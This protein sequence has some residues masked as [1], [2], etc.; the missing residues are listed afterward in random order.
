MKTLLSLLFITVL[1]FQQ[2]IWANSMLPVEVLGSEG[3]IEEVTFEWTRQAKAATLYL[4]ANNLKYSNKGSLRLND[5]GWLLFNNNNADCYQPD[6]GFG[7]IGG[8]YSTIRFTIPIDK[9]GRL[10]KGGNILQFRFDKSDEVS[11][12]YR[13][14]DINFLDENGTFLLGEDQ[15]ENDDPSMWEVPEI[16][17]V[18]EGKQLWYT[19]QL[20]QS[21]AGKR[22][23]ATCSDCHAQ[24][25][26]DLKYFNYSNKSIIKRAEFHGL[27]TMEGK[28]IAD[29]IR[30]LDTPAP[31]QARPWN[32]PYQPGPG[33]DDIPAIEWAAGA[34]LEWVLDR[35]EQMMP[36]LLPYGTSKEGIAKVFD[37]KATLNVREMPVAI[38]FPDWKQW[39]P[40]VHPK[41]LMTKKDWTASRMYTGYVKVR[42]LFET[43]GTAGLN[44]IDYGL[45]DAIM[46]LSNAGRMFLWEGFQ[47]GLHPWT[48]LESTG[49][50]KNTSNLLN[51]DYKLNIARWTSVK[52]WEIMQEFEVEGVTPKGAPVPEARQWP[53]R[54][55]TLFALAPHIVGDERFTSHFQ[56]QDPVVGYYE[57]TAWYQ[58]QLTLN[59]GMRDPREVEPVDWSYN[60]MHILRASRVTR[61]LEP[62]RYFQNIL[63]CYQQ[64]DNHH[65]V[66]RAGWT[67]REVSPWRNYSSSDGYDDDFVQ[68]DAYEPGLRAKLTGAMV[69]EFTRKANEFE[70]SDWPVCEDIRNRG[71][72]YWWCIEPKDYVPV[73]SYDAC[74]FMPREDRCGDSLDA[75]EADAINILLPKLQEIKVDENII[76][77]LAQWAESMWPKGNWERYF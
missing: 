11:S 9:L 54:H 43:Q 74:Q 25:G 58:L 45:H 50:S 76:S 40:Q 38:Q 41:D 22:I 56:G 68:L 26:R 3:T 62:L 17:T 34:G 29:Y 15:F 31:K 57:S 70:I 47:K 44:E 12:G 66:S 23:K 7:C 52:H 32:P 28:Q 24:D 53:T 27:S 48:V 63:K 8:G 49:T 39:L 61:H 20:I 4:Q 21:P 77:D 36:Y 71:A 37:I 46:I 14:L 30:A 13:I 67:M 60:F 65:K 75:I 55:W 1:L 18:S 35:D 2:A 72:A 73:E 5:G 19:A 33:L 42:N 69:R 64:R 10:Q 16:N 6:E 51:E 59:A